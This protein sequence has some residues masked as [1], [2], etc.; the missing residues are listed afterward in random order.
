MLSWAWYR[1]HKKCVG[2]RYVEPL[3]LHLV[4]SMDHV[5]HHGASV[6]KNVDTLFFMLVWTPWHI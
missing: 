3:F 4:G 5:M 1:F 2:T 6:A